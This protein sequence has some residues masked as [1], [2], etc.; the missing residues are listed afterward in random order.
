MDLI[1]AAESVPAMAAGLDEIN[2]LIGFRRKALTRGTYLEGTSA[3]PSTPPATTTAAPGA[4]P[5]LGTIRAV[6]ADKRM[7]NGDKW[8]PVK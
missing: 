4:T 1:N 3:S 6:G 2:T 7:W 8:V 5:A